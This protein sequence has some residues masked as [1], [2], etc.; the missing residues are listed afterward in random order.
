[1]ICMLVCERGGRWVWGGGAVGG[2][3]AVQTI[4]RPAEPLPPSLIDHAAR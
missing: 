4:D 1:M 2:V 3:Y